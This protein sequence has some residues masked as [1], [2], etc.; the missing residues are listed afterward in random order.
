LPLPFFILTPLLF[1]KVDSQCGACAATRLAVF[2]F[3]LLF[4]FITLF[5]ILSKS[6]E[7]EKNIKLLVWLIA[8]GKVEDNNIAAD[9]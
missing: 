6:F 8:S 7:K 1:I 5:L 4:V 2:L 3:L 9:S